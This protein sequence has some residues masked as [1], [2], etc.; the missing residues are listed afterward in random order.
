MSIVA[1]PLL[2]VQFFWYGVLV[3]ETLAQFRL[4]V[5]D[6]PPPLAYWD[7]RAERSGNKR[8]GPAGIY[9]PLWS[10]PARDEC[11]M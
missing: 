1:V 7:P 10:A 4:Q 11:A 3:T 5:K 8:R 9:L 6:H 2:P